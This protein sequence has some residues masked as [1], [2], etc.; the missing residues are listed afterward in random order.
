VPAIKLQ[1]LVYYAHAWSL[2]CDA[3]LLFPE[4]IE[5]WAHG[6]VVREL[7]AVRRGHS[8]L[9]AGEITEGDPHQRDTLGRKTLDAALDFY[10]TKASA[11]LLEQAQTE[12]PWLVARR[13]L[14]ERERGRRA[15]CLASMTEYHGHLRAQSYCARS[16][17]GAITWRIARSDRP[18]VA[19]C[20]SNRRRSGW[21]SGGT[22]N[23]Q[24]PVSGPR[25]HPSPSAASSGHTLPRRWL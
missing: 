7:A 9:Q 5:A 4:R 14:A 10:G 12:D 16:D 2:A 13:D 1:T 21:N 23:R 6:P 3:R 19:V 25:S 8:L 20:C 22:V 11:W 18:P 17:P 15:M 24:V